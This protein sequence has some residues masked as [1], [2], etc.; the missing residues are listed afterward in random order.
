M[1]RYGA[2]WGGV[3]CSP[4]QLA[5]SRPK[6]AAHHRAC[7][8]LQVKMAVPPFDS[9]CAAILAEMRQSETRTWNK[10]TRASHSDQA[11]GPVDVGEVLSFLQQRRDDD[12]RPL[13]ELLGDP[14]DKGDG[15]FRLE[16]R[17][18]VAACPH[19]EFGMAPGSSVCM[20]SSPA[21]ASSHLATVLGKA[22]H[23]VGTVV[24]TASSHA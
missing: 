20:L 17:G 9:T 21:S 10:R 1:F 18:G 6:P 23:W 19:S 2:S 15:W 16:V 24:S 13:R 8:P 5:E 11:L 7:P 14:V 3:I 4:C 22:T 12:G